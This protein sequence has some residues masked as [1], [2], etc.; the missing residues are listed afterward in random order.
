MFS[1]SMNLAR[2]VDEEDIKIVSFDIDIDIDIA[3]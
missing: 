1:E 2:G 3:L